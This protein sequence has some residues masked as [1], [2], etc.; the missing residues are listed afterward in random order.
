MF[1]LGFMS[2]IPMLTE[3]SAKALVFVLGISLLIPSAVVWMLIKKQA[4]GYVILCFFLLKGILDSFKDE[5]PDQNLLYIGI[6][7]N[8]AIMGYAIFLKLKLFPF[9]NFFNT[10]KDDNGVFIYKKNLTKPSA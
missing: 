9:Q 5:N 8:L 6:A 10:R 1:A 2:V 7:I 4:L 3:L